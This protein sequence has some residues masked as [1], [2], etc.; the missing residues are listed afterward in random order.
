[1]GWIDARIR[2]ALGNDRYQGMAFG[3]IFLV[4][5]GI[6]NLGRGS[7]HVFRSDGGAA[8]LAGIDLTQNGEVI[9]TLFASMGLTQIL[10]GVI[11]LV[12]ALR[13]RALAP[14]LLG[15]HLLQQIGAAIILWR[16]RP[17]PVEE[18]GKLVADVLIPVVAV[19]FLCG[20]RRPRARPDSRQ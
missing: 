18:P 4:L 15:Y 8:S 11:D 19:A 2:Q 12:V 13:C 6:L 20:T 3:W 1:M 14:L 9:L 17:Q 10:L 5:I 7:I 16:W